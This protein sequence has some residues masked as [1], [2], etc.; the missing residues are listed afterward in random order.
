[1]KGVKETTWFNP[2]FN[3]GVKSHIVKLLSTYFHNSSV[4]YKIFNRNTVKLSYSCTSNFVT[5]RKSQNARI[6]KDSV[7]QSIVDSERC[8]CRDKNKYPLDGV[9]ESEG[10][11]Y[12]AEVN[13]GKGQSRIYVL[14]LYSKRHGTIK[15]IIQSR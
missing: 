9:C 7:L 12:K 4:F 8:N 5:T 1:M 15:V 10:F 3:L 14:K 11:V 6:S 13:D 2:L